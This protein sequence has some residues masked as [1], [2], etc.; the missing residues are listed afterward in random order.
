[1]SDT[2][3]TLEEIYKKTDFSQKKTKIICTMG[4]AC[5]DSETLE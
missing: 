4:P 3:F 1:M 5:W 2:N